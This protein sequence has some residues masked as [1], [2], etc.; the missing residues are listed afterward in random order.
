[1]SC[2]PVSVKKLKVS[3]LREEL[4]K[5]RLSDK[6][7]KAELMERLQTALDQEAGGGGGGEPGNGTAEEM[8]EAASEQ[9]QAQQQQQQAQQQLLSPASGGG[10]DQADD[11]EADFGAGP[12]DEEEDEED[13]EAMELGEEN[14]EGAAGAARKEAAEDLEEEEEEDDDE[15]GDD[16]GFQEGEDDEEEAPASSAAPS[17]SSSA[18]GGGGGNANGHGAQ[19]SKEAPAK[20]GSAASAEASA[21]APASSAQTGGKQS[22][23]A[24]QKP[25]GAPRPGEVKT[26]QKP[27][28]KKRGVKRPR[29]D[30]GR[31]YFEYI[32]ENKYSRAKSP[33]P[34]VE[35]E[36]EHFDDTVVC[37]DTYNCDLHF[38]I[39]R[40][41]FSASSLTMESFAFLWAG[42]RASYGVSKGKVCFEMKV[43]EKIPVKHLYTKDIDIH[44]VRVGWS[45]NTSGMLLG[46]EEFSYGYSLKGIKACNC[47]MEDFGEKFDENDV[48]GCFANF[49]GDEVEL[50]YSKNGQE[51]GVAFKISKEVLSGRPLFPHVLCHNC[52]VEFN[53][54]QK[55]EPYFP[56]PEGYTF[57]QNVPLEDRFRG[58]KGPEQKKECEVVMMIGLPGAGKT[59]WVTKHAAENPGKYN[60][61]GTNT[62]MDKMM[63]AGFKRQMADTG[64]LNTLLQRAPQCLG[65]FIEIAARKKRNF[66][67]DQ[68]NVSAAAQRRKMCLF[69]GFQR[70]A[71][72]VCPKDEDY[73]QRTQK[74]AEVEGKDL[75]EHAVLKMKGNFTLP[76]V[77][78]CF[79]EII[80]VELQKEEAQKLLEQYK[81]ESK[82]ALPPE[83]KQNTGSKK[84]NKK[85]GKNQFNRGGQRGRGGFNMRGNFRGGVP[86]NRG[87]YNRRGG[88]MPQRGGGG[89]G[90]AI[91]YPY[92]RGPVFPAR[93][94]G[95]GGGYTN[96][97]NYNRGG[98]P[99]RGNYNQNFRGRGNNRG[100]KN[101]SQG[102]N[103]WQQ[104]QFWGQKPWSQH[105]HQGYY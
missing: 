96:R 47:E 27:G 5:R 67:L 35:E 41:R 74:K 40:D 11:E 86:G 56:I 17:A 7:L 34:P 29:E 57:I 80:Y 39:S 15:N 9:Q 95:G 58:P 92:P 24:Q 99:N 26:E 83:K 23:P 105:F 18:G 78:E 21:S 93:G 87:G 30:H 77:S 104:G 60:I 49:D 14:G 13:E 42:G 20:G 72:V 1:M 90:G 84:S 16:Q 101:Q 55:D 44:E 61:L 68:T 12:G 36:D 38:K 22:S 25:G 37:L 65:K 53:F 82:K 54:G 10:P 2:S 31:G 32:E 71:V 98:M 70:K 88:N 76:E 6:G 19:A 94:G 48:I 28:E 45:L 64:K 50:S 8:A 102:Y 91:G 103:Q 97:G 46:E 52:A 59:T 66:I 33:Q 100:Y 43:T 73:K 79:D 81:E 4:K 3:E 62:I 51:L 69:A 85:S 75:P 89:S 63:V